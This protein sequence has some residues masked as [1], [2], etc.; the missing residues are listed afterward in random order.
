MRLAE[1]F[2]GQTS[3]RQK[4]GARGLCVYTNLGPSFRK[5][6]A[7]LPAIKNE[8]ATQPEG[9]RRQKQSPTRYM[10]MRQTSDKSDQTTDYTPPDRC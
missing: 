5:S 1:S 10:G 7:K 4:S 2:Y 3:T 6:K 9:A 8:K